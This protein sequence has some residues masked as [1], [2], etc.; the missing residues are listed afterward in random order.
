MSVAICELIATMHSLIVLKTAKPPRRFPHVLSSWAMSRSPGA[1][2]CLSGVAR[3]SE[4]GL[5]SGLIWQ[6]LFCPPKLTNCLLY[7]N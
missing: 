2:N 5:F 3:Q 1:M 7:E 6:E 4:D